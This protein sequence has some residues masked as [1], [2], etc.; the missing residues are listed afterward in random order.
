MI[1]IRTSISGFWQEILRVIA[2]NLSFIVSSLY[3]AVVSF[4]NDVLPSGYMIAVAQARSRVPFTALIEVLLIEIIAEIIR[5]SLIRVPTKIGM[6]IG[7]V[8][9][10]IIGQASVAAG[11]FSPLILIVI[12]LSLISSFVPADYSIIDPFRV[13]KFPLIL[14]TGF[15][16]LFGLRFFILLVLSNL[17]SINTFGVPYMAPYAPFNLKDALKS[18]FYSKSFANSRP[19]FLRTKNRFRYPPGANRH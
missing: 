13:L 14:V 7:I 5:E 17:V 2:L 15:L 8:G 11:I 10:I 16:G 6:A 12:S 1:F 4:H 3:V 19:R 18:M 9:A